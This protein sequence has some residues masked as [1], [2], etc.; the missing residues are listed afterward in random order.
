L[1]YPP[2]FFAVHLAAF[3]AWVPDLPLLALTIAALVVTARRALGGR[4]RPTT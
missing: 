3:G 1:C 4:P 2:V